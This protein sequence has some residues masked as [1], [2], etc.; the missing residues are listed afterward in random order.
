[1]TLA[2]AKLSEDDVVA[3]RDDGD[4][5]GGRRSSLFDDSDDGKER[6]TAQLNEIA[7]SLS[8]VVRRTVDSVRLLGGNCEPS[9]FAQ[10]ASLVASSI[11]SLSGGVESLLNFFAIEDCYPFTATAAVKTAAALRDACEEALLHDL[12]QVVVQ[13]ALLIQAA[14]PPVRE[15]DNFGELEA[16][17]TELIQTFVR[18]LREVVR[19]QLIIIASSPSSSIT[20]SSSSPSSF[21]SESLPM[22]AAKVALAP[23]EESQQEGCADSSST[24]TTPTSPPHKVRSLTSP[25]FRMTARS[26]MISAAAMGSGVVRAE[27][28]QR[29]G[30][31]R[32]KKK[33]KKKKSRDASFKTMPASSSSP[34]SS[35]PKSPVLPYAHRT[36]RLHTTGTPLAVSLAKSPLANSTEGRAGGTISPGRLDSPLMGSPS[37]S[38]P[39]SPAPSSRNARDSPQASADSGQPVSDMGKEEENDSGRATTDTTTGKAPR[40]SIVYGF[41]VKEGNMHLKMDL[42][43]VEVNEEA[44]AEKITEEDT[45]NAEVISDEQ[46]VGMM[47]QFLTEMEQV[48][49]APS[50]STNRKNGG[51]LISS[52]LRSATSDSELVATPASPSPTI[53]RRSPSSPSQVVASLLDPSV[54]DSEED[55]GMTPSPS[56]S[57]RPTPRTKKGEKARK[58]PSPLGSSK[59]EGSIKRRGSTTKAKTTRPRPRAKE[60]KWYTCRTS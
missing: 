59:S 43:P 12:K 60:G 48:S 29:H 23:G 6:R 28:N 41:K 11:R 27:D 36:S 33:K 25:G 35:P 53:I 13:S 49:P 30:S 54:F 21:S 31:G 7:R 58:Q 22:A 15:V 2:P 56:S 5:D 45:G 37:P 17:F 50:P 51:S 57:P 34:K 24:S 26:A 20:S 16:Q 3:R 8:R 4:G 42:Q 44:A 32:R 38:P 1:M 47:V 52:P 55:D 40:V 39:L 14:R 10:S 46:F 9:L 19:L 18:Q